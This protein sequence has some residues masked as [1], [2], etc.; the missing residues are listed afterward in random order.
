VDIHLNFIGH[1]IAPKEEIPLTPEQIEA[2]RK[3][4]ERRANRR[5]ITRRYREKKKGRIA[6]ETSATA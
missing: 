4:D 3:E 1:F 2:E 6:A 5:E